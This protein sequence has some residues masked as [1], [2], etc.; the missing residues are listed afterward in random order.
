MG[1]THQKS[2]DKLEAI[3]RRAARFVLNQYHTSSRMLDLLGWPSLEQR[4]KTLHLGVMYKIC[5]GLVQCP[6]IK[7]K[8]ATPPPCQ[9][10]THCQ[11]LSLVTTRMQYRGGSFLPR[12][13]RDWNSLSIDTLEAL[14]VD[15]FVSHASHFPSLFFWERESELETVQ[16]FNFKDLW[17]ELKCALCEHHLKCQNNHQHVCGHPR[18]EEDEVKL[19]F[20][21]SLNGERVQ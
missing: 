13:I 19:T 2:I 3:Q 6:I 5:N 17:P 16:Q 20:V 8:L 10:R 18:K 9:R 4:R 7:T 14:T 12:T 1:P 11:Q 15:T 21:L